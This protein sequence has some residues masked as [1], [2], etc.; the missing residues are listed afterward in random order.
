MAAG[1][2]LSHPGPAD[3]QRVQIAPC[4]AHPLR[5]RLKAGLPL[6]RA[7]AAAAREAG[8]NG[9]WLQLDDLLCTALSFVIPAPPPGDGRVAFYSATRVLRGARIVTAGLHLGEAGAIHAHGI[10]TDAAGAAHM[11]HLRPEGTHLSRP[12][13]ITGW[14]LDGAFFRRRFD[15]ETGFPLF[16][17][18]RKARRLS[19]G[20]PARLIRLRPHLDLAPTL[21]ALSCAGTRFLGL[22]SLVGTRFA[23]GAPLPGPATEIL[24]LGQDR[25]RLWVASVGE[26]GTAHQGW[27]SGTNR[28]CITAEL[29]LIDE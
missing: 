6:D 12:A 3:R 8:V 27:L 16:T 9:A 24:I 14:R 29:L 5:L 18:H 13:W 10:W 1:D 20:R 21:A 22:G 11:G 7:I 2:V 28:T 17:T 4:R 19:S 26:D 23:T 25:S 15:P